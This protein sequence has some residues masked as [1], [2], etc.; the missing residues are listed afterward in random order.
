[1]VVDVIEE[2]AL[3]EKSCVQVL[4][5]LITKADGEIH[6]LEKD[7]VSLQSELSLGEDEEWSE[8]CCNTL[9]EKINCLDIS[10]RSLK[11][12]NENDVEVQLLMHR[13]PAEEVHEIVKALLRNCFQKKEEQV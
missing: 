11:N 4:G 5:I 12:S 2:D 3:N 13:G 8:L 10:I 6:E 1:M 7:L 9:T